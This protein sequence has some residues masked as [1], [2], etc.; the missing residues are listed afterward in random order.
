M[1]KR[2]MGCL[3]CAVMAQGVAAEPPAGQKISRA[4]SVPATQGPAEFFTG[5]VSVTPAFPATDGIQASGG[6]VTFQAGARSAWHTH[7]AGQHLLVTAGV[8]LTQEWGKPIQEIKAGDVIWCPPGIKHWH[9]ASPESPMTHL[10]ITGALNGKY[11][12]WLEKVSDEQYRA[13]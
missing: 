1:F 5:T 9:G 8:G 7:P 3:T 11:V 4:G 2:L 12:D 6:H 13:R 10:A